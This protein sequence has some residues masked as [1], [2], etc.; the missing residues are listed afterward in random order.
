M[1]TRV[2][3]L[4]WYTSLLYYVLVKAGNPYRKTISLNLYI[5]NLVLQTLPN[6]NLFRSLY[7]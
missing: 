3:T 1:V 6:R 4:N 5:L 2:P 7:S